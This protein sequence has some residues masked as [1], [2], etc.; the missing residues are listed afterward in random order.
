MAGTA[1][2]GNERI[3]YI[4][5]KIQDVIQEEHRITFQYYEYTPQKEKV[6]KHGGYTEFDDE[7]VRQIIQKIAVEDEDTIRIH[8]RDSEMVMEQE[9]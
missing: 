3:Y 9:L 2:P 5:D 1:K 7:F 4:V 8:F 6:L